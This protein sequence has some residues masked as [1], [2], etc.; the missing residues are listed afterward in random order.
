MQ[1]RIGYFN[2]VTEYLI[3]P[4]LERPDPRSLPLAFLHRRDR[5]LAVLRKFA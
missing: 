5:L 4:D 1:I 3:E 2:V